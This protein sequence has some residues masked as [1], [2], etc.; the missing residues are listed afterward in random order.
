MYLY[1]ETYGNLS[2]DVIISSQISKG[3]IQLPENGTARI[4]FYVRYI[5]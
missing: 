3:L 2:S 1:S 4:N 5:I